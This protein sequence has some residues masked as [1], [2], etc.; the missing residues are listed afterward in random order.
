M[1]RE[2]KAEYHLSKVAHCFRQADHI[3]RQE[4]ESNEDLI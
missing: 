4:A 1:A 2:H 3:E